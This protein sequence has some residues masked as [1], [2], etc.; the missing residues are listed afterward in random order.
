MSEE[1]CT[2]DIANWLSDITSDY[3]SENS[4]TTRKRKCEVDEPAFTTKRS[5]LHRTQSRHR[6]FQHQTYIRPA[7]SE[8]NLNVWA[9]SEGKVRK[10]RSLPVGHIISAFL[11][12]N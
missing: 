4:P 3:E 10:T 7:L 1:D 11:A 6:P 9:S 5:R 2:V 12:C 8:I